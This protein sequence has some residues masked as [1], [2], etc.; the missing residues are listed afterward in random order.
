MNTTLNNIQPTLHELNL[1]EL[2]GDRVKVTLSGNVIKT[3]YAK[4]CAN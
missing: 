3:N 2:Y 4:L 1:G